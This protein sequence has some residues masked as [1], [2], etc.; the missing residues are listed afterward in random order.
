MKPFRYRFSKLLNPVIV[1]RS[2]SNIRIN[3]IYSKGTFLLN[4]PPGKVEYVEI[5]V[6]TEN[7]ISTPEEAG[8][9]ASVEMKTVKAYTFFCVAGSEFAEGGDGSES[10]PWA[11]VNYALNQLQPIIDC[12]VKTYCCEYI[13]L[14]CSGVCNYEVHNIQK[15]GNGEWVFTNFNGKN[16]FILRDL[17]IGVNIAYNIVA[18]NDE[19]SYAREEKFIVR[20][21]YDTLFY[22]LE[23]TA[24]VLV[25]V[26]S[27]GESQT[28]YAEANVW[29]IYNCSGTFYLCDVSI[30]TLGTGRGNFSSSSFGEGYGE[31]IGFFSCI[32]TFIQCNTSGSGNGYGLCR[33]GEN[34]NK[35]AEAK[36]KGIG[37]NQCSGIFYFCAGYGEG[38]SESDASL[39][40]NDS[41]HSLSAASS[42][43]GFS[44][45]S[46]NFYSCRGNGTAEAKGAGPWDC[47]G[48]AV[49]YG[50]SWCSGKFFTCDGE[51]SAIGTGIENE[52]VYGSG[53]SKSYAFY[54][55]SDL[56]ISCSG[57]V[58]SVASG[59]TFQC[60]GCG[61]QGCNAEFYDCSSSNKI[62]KY[63]GS[64]NAY[65]CENFECDI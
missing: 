38:N 4:I 15:D 12:F 20:G 32:G 60:R 51:S 29:G 3:G 7:E 47:D 17:E 42:G 16:R 55:C 19:S 31:G 41:S 63:K 37:F 43:T 57:N 61:F 9:A 35:T 58:E 26:S 34:D 52:Y 30:Y 10:N 8:N 6:L 44:N 21:I 14:R 56:L 18:K 23:T 50:F 2:G 59:Y 1:N 28:G 39:F 5:P 62:C 27:E 24:S 48:S 54:A 40:G 45:C 46:G 53:C 11:S 13:Q 49:A 64:F 22:S 25:D 36:G 33:S 65:I